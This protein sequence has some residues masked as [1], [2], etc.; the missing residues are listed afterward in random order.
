MTN[1]TGEPALD[2]D[3]GIREIPLSDEVVFRGALIDVSHMQVRLPNG[4]QALREVVRHKGAAAIVPVGTTGESA[5]LSVEEH[6]EVIRHTVTAVAGRRYLAATA[7]T[8]SA[9][10]ARVRSG[11]S[12]TSAMDRSVVSHNP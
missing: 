4:R 6:S 10:T 8:S 12:A 5:T 3:A 7:L 9:V 2:S 1:P 11:H